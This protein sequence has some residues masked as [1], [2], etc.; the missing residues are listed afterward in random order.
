MSYN[1]LVKEIE[2]FNGLDYNTEYDLT[3]KGE[4][5][6]IIIE[7]N[8]QAHHHNTGSMANETHTTYKTTYT[9]GNL[10]KI[11]YYYNDAPILEKILDKYTCY[12][13]SKSDLLD[14]LD[15]FKYKGITF[16]ETD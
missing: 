14:S 8:F 11:N 4:T 1:E 7:T 6:T 5:L 15:Y 2:E 13:M 9:G 10:F 16:K 3:L 12:Y